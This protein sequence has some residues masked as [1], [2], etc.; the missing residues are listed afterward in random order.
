MLNKKLYIVDIIMSI[1]V[2]NFNDK[3][4]NFRF[5]LFVATPNIYI[6]NKYKYAF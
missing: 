1:C 4:F 2:I 5:L 3:F 6:G